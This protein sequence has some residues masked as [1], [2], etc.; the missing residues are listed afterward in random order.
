MRLGEASGGTEVIAAQSWRI[1]QIYYKV[2]WCPPHIINA[3]SLFVHFLLVDIQ[4]QRG[5]FSTTLAV[6]WSDG[7]KYKLLLSM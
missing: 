1:S 6:T 4:L 3:H 2:L 7:Q 5:R